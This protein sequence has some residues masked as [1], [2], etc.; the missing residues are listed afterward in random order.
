MYITGITLLPKQVL[1]LRGTSVGGLESAPSNNTV[2]FG[3]VYKVSDISNTN[4][5]GYNVIF[6]STM[7]RQVVDTSDNTSQFYIMDESAILATEAA[8]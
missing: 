4:Y 7:A 3:V 5:Q 8:L 6:D 1:V 2:W